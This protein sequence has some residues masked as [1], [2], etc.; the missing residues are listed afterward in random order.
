MVKRLLHIIVILATLIT[1][2]SCTHQESTS[3]HIISVTILP[4]KFLAEQIAGER[5]EINCLVTA[6]N[7]PES[8][9]PTP[10]QLVEIENSEAYLRVGMLGFEIAW[11][12]R[13]AR[14]NPAMKIFDTSQGIDMIHGT[15]T[16]TH[17]NGV[18]HTSSSIDPHVWCSPKN[19]RIMAENIYQ[20]LVEIDPTGKDYYKPRYEH[21][22]QRI[23]SVDNV[24]TQT[25]LPVKGKTFAIYHPSLSYLARDYG[26]HQLCIENMGKE[27]SA[28]ALKNIVEEAR[29]KEVD[30]VFIQSEFNPRQ[31]HT[32][33]Q[34][35]G[36]ETVNI[37]PLNYDWI[38]EMITIAYAIAHNRE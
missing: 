4:Q 25:L 26:L 36:A 16:H 2:A 22:I 34:E 27:S 19:A 9:D 23:D 35:L 13:L 5:Y 6:N 18:T 8:Y 14:N 21:L 32:F 7:N 33:A 38:N 20:A 3:Q 15:H 28:F 31:V 29:N 37:N 12:D 17:H 10:Q 1:L 11:M 24:I 30:V